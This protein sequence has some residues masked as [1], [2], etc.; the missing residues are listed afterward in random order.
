MA[1]GTPRWE[2]KKNL[3]RKH[4]ER[5]RRRRRRLR[6][7]VRVRVRRRRRAPAAAPA[8]AS[9][10]RLGLSASRLDA[11]ARLSRRSVASSCGQSGATTTRMVCCHH[12]YGCPFGDRPP[13]PPPR[14]RSLCCRDAFWDATRGH[15]RLPPLA[16]RRSATAPSASSASEPALGRTTLVPKAHPSC[17]SCVCCCVFFFFGFCSTFRSDFG[18]ASH[19]HANARTDSAALKTDCCCFCFCFVKECI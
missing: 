2:R 14:P 8:P 11:C 13:R 19:S 7:R 4:R 16:R 6:V 9:S 17:P 3:W 12:R 1:P 10:H 18:L 5:E 15:R